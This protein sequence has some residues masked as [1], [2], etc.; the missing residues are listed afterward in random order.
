MARATKT[1][2]MFR[3]QTAVA[4]DITAPA[5][6]VWA[7]LTDLPGFVRWNSTVLSAEGRIAEGETVRIQVKLAPERTFNLKV[8]S[9]VPNAKMVWSDGNALFRGV[10]TY[11]ITPQGAGVRFEMDEVNSGLLLPMIRGSLPDFGP[12]FEQ[13]AEDLKAAAEAS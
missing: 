7:L 9:V 13:Y 11:Q 12:S 8:S 5:E 2:A 3:Q 1:R 10:R 6:R 4:I